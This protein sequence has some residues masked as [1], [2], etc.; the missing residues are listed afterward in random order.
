MNA[1]V[2]LFF[3][4]QDCTKDDA[5]E[6]YTGAIKCMDAGNDIAFVKHSTLKEYNETLGSE[7]DDKVRFSVSQFLSGSF[8]KW[9]YILV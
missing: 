7:V 4:L 2:K 8:S 3:P 9:Y 1:V 5:Y 6:G